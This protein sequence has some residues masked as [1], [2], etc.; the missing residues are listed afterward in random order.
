M[1]PKIITQKVVCFLY[2]VKTI[3]KAPSVIVIRKKV[4]YP[5]GNLKTAA[6]SNTAHTIKNAFIFYK[7]ILPFT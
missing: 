6:N 1:R 5:I 7:L 2:S 4:K 3:N